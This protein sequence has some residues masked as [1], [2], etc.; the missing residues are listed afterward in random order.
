MKIGYPEKILWTII[1]LLIVGFPNRSVSGD[2]PHSTPPKYEIWETL[3]LSAADL[4]SG[5]SFCGEAEGGTPQLWKMLSGNPG[6]LDLAGLREAMGIKKDVDLRTL[7]P[8][9]LRA[10]HI[11]VAV[12]CKEGAPDYLLFMALEFAREEDAVEFVRG[13]AP[14]GSEGNF[15]MLHRKRF[16]ISISGQNKKHVGLT[17]SDYPQYQ[18][19][20]DEVIGSIENKLEN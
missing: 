12:I 16:V 7:Q 15:R 20:S 2:N 8:P 11:Y 1:F 4:P 9:L 19:W 3:T 14:E 18:K 10:E 17:V 13:A 5:Y 6:F